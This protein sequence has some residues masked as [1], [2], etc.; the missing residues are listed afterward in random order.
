MLPVKIDWREQNAPKAYD[1]LQGK[2]GRVES[3]LESAICDV[4]IT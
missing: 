3:S 2:T 4:C 1:K